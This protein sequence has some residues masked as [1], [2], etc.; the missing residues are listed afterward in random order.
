MQKIISADSQVSSSIGNI[1]HIC[2]QCWHKIDDFNKFCDEAEKIHRNYINTCVKKDVEFNAIIIDSTAT[3][4]PVTVECKPDINED[5][6]DEFSEIHTEVVFGI[7]NQADD[8]ND[9]DFED[10]SDGKNVTGL[11]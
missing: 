9:Q 1:K 10:D 8:L 2:I 5:E 3:S 11:A 4:V 7:E 6:I